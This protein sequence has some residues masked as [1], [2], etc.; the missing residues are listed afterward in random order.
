[1]VA[2]RPA[3]GMRASGLSEGLRGALQP[4][5]AFNPRWRAPGHTQKPVHIFGVLRTHFGQ[6]SACM[7]LNDQQPF[8]DLRRKILRR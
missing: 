2:A 4:Q 8:V 6:L 1:M 5:D 7:G 3:S